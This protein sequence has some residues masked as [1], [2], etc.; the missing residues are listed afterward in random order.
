MLGESGTSEDLFT[1]F[2]LWENNIIFYYFILM[3]I[4]IKLILVDRILSWII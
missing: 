4:M 1:K 3:G 2:I